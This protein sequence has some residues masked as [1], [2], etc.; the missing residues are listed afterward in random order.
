MPFCVNCGSEVVENARFCRSCGGSIDAI[1]YSHT[2]TKRIYEGTIHKC[3]NCGEVLGSFQ[4]TCSLCGHEIRD[5]TE[6]NAVA[7][8]SERLRNAVSVDEQTRIITSFAIPNNQEDIWEFMIIA[9]S[10]FNEKLFVEKS[11]EYDL[12]DAWMSKIESCYEKA[13]VYVV[14]ARVKQLV[15][16][17]YKE[18]KNRIKKASTESNIMKII[19]VILIGVG[20]LLIMTQILVIQTVG[21]VLLGSGI[22]LAI[23]KPSKEKRGEDVQ[24]VSE[25]STLDA[26]GKHNKNNDTGF[27]SWPLVGKIFW[28][29]LNIYTL[30]IPAIIYACKRKK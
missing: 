29:I 7:A 24:P 30:G 21:L 16:A 4:T 9:S 18:I 13:K 22:F 23:K 8:F 14:D 19:P 2:E 28:I 27:S 15:E 11:K 5:N 25:K 3:P 10:N 1:P 6:S 20:F 26:E 12:T 17:R